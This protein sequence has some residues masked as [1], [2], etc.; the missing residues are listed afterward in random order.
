MQGGSIQDEERG[1][2]QAMNLGSE[3]TGAVIGGILSTQ[4]SLE[5][6]DIYWVSQFG[7]TSLMVF[8]TKQI[9]Q[10][11]KS[12]R[13]FIAPKVLKK[14]KSVNQERADGRQTL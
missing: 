14:G 4:F 6:R 11:H 9:C 8:N 10:E 7:L 1:P 13:N 5:Q 3:N 12:V 2:P